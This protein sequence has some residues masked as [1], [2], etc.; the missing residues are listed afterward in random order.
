MNL[1]APP[2]ER[3]YAPRPAMLAARRRFVF[4]VVFCFF[5]HALGIALVVRYGGSGVPAPEQQEI[6][7]EIVAEQPPDPPQPPPQQ[8]QQ[9]PAQKSQWDEKEATDSP[10][11]KNEE[12]PQKKADAK[13][14]HAP[15]AEP[16]PEPAEMKPAKDPAP[17]E[18]TTEA[19]TAEDSAPLQKD[20]RTDGEPLKAAD[21]PKPDQAQTKAE[22]MAPQPEKPQPAAKP[23]TTAKVAPDYAFAAASSY[24]PSTAGNAASTYLSIVYDMVH[25]HM[26]LSKVAA[27]R[28]HAMGEIEF[29]VDYGGGLVGA[30]VLK[31]T[32]LPDL[33]AAA[34]AAIRAAA[35][36]PL[37]P[38][39][40]GIGLRMKYSGHS[41]D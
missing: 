8:S 16:T 12:K 35:P 40:S 36:F 6:A 23:P 38:T 1:I 32:G 19:K 10:R 7:V 37:P 17:S 5:L 22:T 31:S 39:G 3:P 29:Y 18:K 41:G 4:I 24:M 2:E 34:M 25:A 9:Q 13:E 11:A 30:K 28:R 21:Q 26:N 33:D 27:G 20:D 15:K 14:S